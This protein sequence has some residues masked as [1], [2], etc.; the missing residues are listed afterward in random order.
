MSIHDVIALIGEI[1]AAIGGI[2]FILALTVALA[3]LRRGYRLSVTPPAAARP[4]A[5]LTLN[6]EVLSSAQVPQARRGM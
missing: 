2:A 1:L 5:P 4:V 6:G 3:F